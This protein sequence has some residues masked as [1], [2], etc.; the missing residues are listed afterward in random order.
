MLSFIFG[1]RPTRQ[2]VR[3][4]LEAS[5]LSPEEI[6]AAEVEGT[7]ELLA[8]DQVVLP[9][10]LEYDID[11]LAETSGLQVDEIRG[12]WRALGFADPAEGERVFSKIDVEILQSVSAFQDGLTDPLLSLQMTRVLGA[13]M[14]RFATAVVE[15]G[16]ARSTGRHEAIIEGDTE[17]VA[18]YE[19][20]SLA[21]RS[22]NLLPFLTEVMEY[23]FRRHLRAAARRRITLAT[24]AEGDGLTVGFADMVRF[25]K[26]SQQLDDHGLARLLTQFG[27]ITNET[28][29]TNGGRIIKMIGDEAMFTAEVPEQAAQIG[30]ELAA[31][32]SKRE[33][34]PGVRVGLASGPVLARDGDVYGPVVNLASRL[35][36]ASR[37]DSVVVSQATRDHLVGDPAFRLRSLGMKHLRHIGTV[38]LY[39]LNKGSG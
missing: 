11:E 31:V 39:R 23:A 6:D 7:D 19:A 13:S 29:A 18:E 16:E 36:E 5:G 26:L 21:V 8:I 1:R 22:G 27:E 14:A 25:T 30:L 17:V 28:V 10:A 37:T 3:D 15:A 20:S 32:F 35:V 24:V 33:D 9:D 12:Y 38:R 34:L 4:V 2:T